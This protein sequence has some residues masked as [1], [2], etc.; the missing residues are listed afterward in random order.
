MF[1]FCSSL[2]KKKYI[3]WS[4]CWISVILFKLCVIIKAIYLNC[5]KACTLPQYYVA[6][7]KAQNWGKVELEKWIGAGPKFLKIIFESL[8]NSKKLI[9]CHIRL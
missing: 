6:N 3:F 9:L 8:I 2:D 1:N 5:W 7:K 4:H